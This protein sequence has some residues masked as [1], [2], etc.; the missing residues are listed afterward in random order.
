MSTYNVLEERI[1][2][3]DQKETGYKTLDYVR[4]QF[5]KKYRNIVNF[6][7]DMYTKFRLCSMKD[8]QR[9]MGGLLAAGKLS[10][11][12]VEDIICAINS[13]RHGC[14]EL[15]NSVALAAYTEIKESAQQHWLSILNEADCQSLVLHTTGFRTP[16]GEFITA[17]ELKK[18]WQQ[19]KSEGGNIKEKD[20]ESALDS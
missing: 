10:S 8:A 15:R 19:K 9:L 3:I 1:F 7:S 11:N 2:D 5:P 4:E 16:Y 6:Y 12:D 14:S 13:T 18:R 17:Y 20:D